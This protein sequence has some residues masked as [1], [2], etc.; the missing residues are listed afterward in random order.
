MDRVFSNWKTTVAGVAFMVVI[1]IVYY[2][3]GPDK[4]TALGVILVGGLGAFAKD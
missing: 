2:F 4:A 1:G 3:Q